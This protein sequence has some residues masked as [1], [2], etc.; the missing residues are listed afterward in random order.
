MQPNFHEIARKGD[1]ATA[2]ERRELR[3]A[4]QRRQV[5]EDMMELRGSFFPGMDAI[6]R[7]NERGETIDSLRTR[8][9]G[10]QKQHTEEVRTLYEWHAQDYHDEM[11]DISR[12]HPDIVD[13]PV[14][15]FYRTARAAHDLRVEFDNELDA[16]YHAHLRTVAVLRRRL[17][18]KE[19]VALEAQMKQD[20]RFPQTIEEFGTLKHELQVRTAKFLVGDDTIKERFR[21]Q[22]GWAWRDVERLVNTFKS[23][24]DWADHLRVLL[25]TDNALQEAGDP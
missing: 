6:R 17:H 14:D 2:A 16:H 12:A 19:K 13:Q 18:V 4:V 23:D 20:Q 25:H 1:A 5:V 9:A 10:L 7:D 15:A 3:D 11:A 21:D 22:Y 24:D 8:I